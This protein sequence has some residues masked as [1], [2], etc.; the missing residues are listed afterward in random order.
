MEIRKLFRLGAVIVILGL[1]SISFASETKYWEL[2]KMETF[3]KGEEFQNLV[4]S[5]KGKMSIGF[6]YTS[7]KIG[8]EFT[9]WSAIL[10]KQGSYYIGTGAGNIYKI[11]GEKVEKIFSTGEMLVTSLVKVQDTIFAATIPNGKIFKMGADGKW[12]EFA[13]LPCKYIWQI[14]PGGE[15]AYLYAATGNEGKLF[16]INADGSNSILYD[17][18]T[19]NILCL[20]LDTNKN[21]YLGTANKGLLIKLEEGSPE[22]PKVLYNFE[23][24]EVKSIYVVDNIVYSAINS[25][26]KVPPSEFLRIAKEVKDKDAVKPKNGAPT[27]GKDE[28]KDD[29]KKQDEQSNGK[30]GVIQLPPITIPGGG[31]GIKEPTSAVS[32]E[33]WKFQG[34]KVERVTVFPSSYIT[35]IFVD[36]KDVI[37]GTNNSGKV[38]S[39]H[40]DTSFTQLFDFVE[41]QVLAFIKEDNKIKAILA[42]DNAVLHILSKDK[43]LKGTYVSEVF[44]AKYQTAWGNIT[45]R[46]SGKISIQTRTGNVDKPDESWSGWADPIVNFPNKIT[47]P[48]NRFLQFKINFELSDTVVENVKIAYRNENQKPKIKD[49]KVMALPAAP[50]PMAPEGGMLSLH[51]TMKNIG[52]IG[53]DSDGDQLV[54]R[55]FYK[56]IDSKN[57][58]SMTQNPL[59]QPMYMWNVS[60]IPDGKYIVKVEISDE[61]SN[62]A[63]DV[64]KESAESDQFI[65]D[66][67]AAKIDLD[68]SGAKVQGE[69]VDGIS[70]IIKLEYKIDAGE[71]VSV[72]PKDK[73]FDSQKEEFEFELKK[74]GKGTHTIT[75]RAIDQENNIGS[76]SREF[77][78]K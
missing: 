76:I 33:V 44:D 63:E 43:P 27:D 17:T 78:V 41:N 49:V 2:A 40:E 68:I 7:I 61:K 58:I 46:G 35:E 6:N 57:W 8:D 53:E 60:S 4:L 30:D 34:D 47:S 77:E 67:T 42:G 72:L 37:L 55:L 73:L 12:T 20:F 23:G 51:S 21:L 22:K 5:S 14:L 74:L 52:W 13:K 29:N 39:I 54:Y 59:Q 11:T 3:A 64:L 31:D 75:M 15:K 10:D 1:Y 48:K 18:K 45:W 65:I 50:P 16:K 32:S 62:T 69:A 66:N 56:G 36:N 9:A 70:N 38:F 24:Y 19:E 28:K 71:W 26:V 25:G